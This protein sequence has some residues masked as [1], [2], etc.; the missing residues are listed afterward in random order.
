MSFSNDLSTPN[1]PFAYPLNSWRVTIPPFLGSHIGA[2][3][4]PNFD[5]PGMTYLFR[6]AFPRP[7]SFWNFPPRPSSLS[8]IKLDGNTP[9][10]WHCVLSVPAPVAGPFGHCRAV[11]DGTLFP[12]FFLFSPSPPPPLFFRRNKNVLS[13]FFPTFSADADLTFFIRGL[14]F[15]FD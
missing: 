13:P 14:K 4:S 8:K 5:R 1:N 11:L 9:N 12:L 6:R 10:G 3:F 7:P 15:L 2:S